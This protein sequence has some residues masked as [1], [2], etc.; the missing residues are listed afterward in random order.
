MRLGT[1]VERTDDWPRRPFATAVGGPPAASMGNLGMETP[2][3]GCIG[4]RYEYA[5][6]C[7][8][9]PS[10]SSSEESS[11][12]PYSIHFHDGVVLFDPTS[13]NSN[14]TSAVFK[15]CCRCRLDAKRFFGQCRIFIQGISSPFDFPPALCD[16]FA[17]YRLSLRPIARPWVVGVVWHRKKG[18]GFCASATWRSTNSAVETSGPFFGPYSKS[19]PAMDQ[20]FNLFADKFQSKRFRCYGARSVPDR[21]HHG[22][23]VQSWP[24][25]PL[26]Q[27]KHQQ[28]LWHCHY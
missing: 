12:R 11:K 18:L 9:R 25:R 2:M 21:R 28:Q 8:S 16:P 3:S 15:V 6:S 1:N 17:R 27:G 22:A 23:Y 20:P 26:Y 24:Q 14:C 19:I 4:L 10:F 5:A 13:G 7:E